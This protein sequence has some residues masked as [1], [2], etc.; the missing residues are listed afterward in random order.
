MTSK[1][2]RPECFGSGP[3]SAG[4]TGAAGSLDAELAETILA[5]SGNAGT[6]SNPHS[7]GSGMDRLSDQAYPERRAH[8]AHG[9][10]SWSAI[11]A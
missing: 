9:I 3:R 7:I 1:P 5:R 2:F 8:A 6:V 10:E 11:R 4:V